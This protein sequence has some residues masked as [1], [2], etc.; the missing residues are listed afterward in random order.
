MIVPRYGDV[1]IRAIGDS[2]YELV[3]AITHQQI[4]IAPALAVAVK[5]AGEYGGAVWRANVD[6]RGRFLG[7]PVLLMQ[8]K[9]VGIGSG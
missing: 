7:N 5:L 6:K 9:S 3:D 2:S 8:R 1:L 4:A